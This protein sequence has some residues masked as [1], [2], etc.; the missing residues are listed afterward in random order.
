MVLDTTA[1]ETTAST[2]RLN[3]CKALLQGTALGAMA[4]LIFV[5]AV[6][7]VSFYS[8]RSL[9]DHK[10]RSA[11]QDGTIQI[12]GRWAI[13][14]TEGADTFTDCLALES[15][16]LSSDRFFLNLFATYVYEPTK[17]E[18]TCDLLRRSY[19]SDSTTKWT[20]MS[21]S[22][23]WWGSASL[24]KIA[25]GQTDLSLAQ[26][27]D[28]VFFSLIL[29]L[30][31]FTLTFYQS[32]RP[33]SLLFTPYLI[34][35]CLGFSLLNLGRSIS[36]IPEEIFSLLILSIYNLT[37]IESRSLYVRAA[38]YSL[39]GA[40][41]V[42]LD[43][44]SGAVMLV[45][46]IMCCQWIASALSKHR[47]SSSSENR[48][49]VSLVTNLWLVITGA[50]FAIFIRL[51]GYSYSSGN[52]FFD[53]FLQWKNHLTFR[54]GEDAYSVTDVAR[55]LWHTRALPFSG[56]LPIH[57]ADV[58]YALGFLGWV[59]LV[60]LCW[61]LAKKQKLPLDVVLAFLLAGVMIPVWFFIFRQHTMFFGWMTVRFLSLF[62][63]LGMSAAVT[64][65]AIEK[66]R[67]G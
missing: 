29:S 42:Y 57:G 31:L 13:T 66:V 38:C 19:E 4:F 44:W 6:G 50:C 18:H 41:C 43:L 67:A 53:V 34:G 62:A 49:I 1:L 23:Y 56:L 60:P 52:S 26:Y 55:K 51:V 17:V 59:L 10:I 35:V 28:V 58:F 14:E 46:T 11:I 21:Y 47:F 40:V 24:A 9:I 54:L 25:L 16:K 48:G 64:M 15:L 12:P 8:D 37:H 32:F 65:L 5:L 30:G 7:T 22:R 63:G 20:V 3:A 61:G 33:A 36:Q 27:M 39:L 45:P 2:T